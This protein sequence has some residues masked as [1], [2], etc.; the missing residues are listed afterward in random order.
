MTIFSV[1]DDRPPSSL[2]RWN[3]ATLNPFFRS[4][5]FASFRPGRDRPVSFMIVLLDGK[6]VLS[7]PLCRYRHMNSLSSAPV[8]SCRCSRMDTGIILNGGFSFFIVTVLSLSLS[9]AL[10]VG[11]SGKP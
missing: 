3:A 8:N 11:A 2:L 6:A 10:V 5:F 1:M 9:L 7:L 4:P